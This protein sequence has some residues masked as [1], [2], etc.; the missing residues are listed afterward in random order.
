MLF[1][2]VLALF[3]D[4][5]LV[6]SVLQ[7]HVRQYTDRMVPAIRLVTPIIWMEIGSLTPFSLK[8]TAQIIQ[9]ATSI[10]VTAVVGHLILPIL[11]IIAVFTVG[12]VLVACE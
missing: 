12:G 8:G 9:T 7:M 10:S 5:F 4:L 2:G 6:T 3:I 11:K 1:F